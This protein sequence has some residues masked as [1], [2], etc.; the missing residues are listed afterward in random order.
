MSKAEEQAARLERIGAGLVGK[1]QDRMEA[2]A[3]IREQAEELKRMRLATSLPY[4]FRC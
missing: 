2:A 3:F 1:D 4:D